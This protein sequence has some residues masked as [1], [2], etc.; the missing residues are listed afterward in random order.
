[1]DLVVEYMGLPNVISNLYSSLPT[2]TDIP[3]AD[4]ATAKTATMRPNASFWAMLYSYYAYKITQ[5]TDF[6]LDAN[7]PNGIADFNA[8]GITL[9]NF[10]ANECSC[11]DINLDGNIVF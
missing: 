10:D 4:F 6:I 5:S 11:Q 8:L 9:G 3:Q 2:I 7:D 1:M